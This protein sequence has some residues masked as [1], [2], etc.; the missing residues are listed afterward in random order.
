MTASALLFE[1][2]RRGIALSA[3][4]GRLRY[5]APVG[6]I[7]PDFRDALVDHKPELVLLLSPALDRQLISN[8]KRWPP[9][10]DWPVGIVIDHPPSAESVRWN[11]WLALAP[12]ADP[13]GDEERLAI[14]DE[15]SLP[16]NSEVP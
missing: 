6:A 2:R 10:P 16:D 11:A 9:T 15:G 3:A 7:D 13:Y 12:G 14:Q 4:D 1:A 8:P 5:K